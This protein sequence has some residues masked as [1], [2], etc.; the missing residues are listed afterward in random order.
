MLETIIVNVL[1]DFLFLLIIVALG[2]ILF[3]FTRRTQLLKFYGIDTSRR[4]VIYL[5]NLR[6]M[7]GGAIGIDD[8]PR[9][10]Q[11]SAAAFGEMLVANRFR[12]LFNYLLPSLSDK[13]GVLSKLLVSD[14]QVQLL[15][16]PLN[17]GQLE[18]S[19]SFVSLGSPAYNATSGFIERELHSRARFHQDGVAMMVEDV[20]P[21]TDTT[22]GFVERIVDHEQRRRVFYAA[23]LSELATTGAAHFLVTEWARLYRKYGSDNAF[24]VMLRFDPMDFR[25][26]SIVFER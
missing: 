25:R 13:P 17:Q 3:V 14:V 23:G 8:Q 2:W 5:S 6:V 15:P 22:Y 21:I 20:P 11:G 10:Y 26:W 19:S 1:S 9:S 16:S 24:V 7:S 4:I 12:D 18:H